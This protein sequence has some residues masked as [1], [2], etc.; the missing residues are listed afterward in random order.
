MLISMSS[1]I[2]N[3]LFL[4]NSSENSLDLPLLIESKLVW[5]SFLSLW[6]SL[7]ED[8]DEVSLKSASMFESLNSFGVIS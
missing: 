3:R 2:D 7:D 5:M 1:L 6:E 8:M 4:N